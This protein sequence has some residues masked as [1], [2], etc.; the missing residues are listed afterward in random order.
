MAI[1]MTAEEIKKY[2]EKWSKPADTAIPVAN[3]VYPSYSPVKKGVAR[4]I[5]LS[6]SEIEKYKN[7]SPEDKFKRAQKKVNALW[8]DIKPV[9]EESLG[10]KVLSGIG[11]LGKEIIR[12]PASVGILGYNE[13]ASLIPA[14]QGNKKKAMEVLQ[15]ERFG[16]KP[17]FTG[18]EKPVEALKKF[19][20]YGIDAATLLYAPAK[21]VAILGK[22]LLKGKALNTFFN[23]VLTGEKYGIA[24]GVSSGLKENKGA[25]EIFES[26]ASG[27]AAGTLF[28]GAFGTVAGAH[29][30]FTQKSIIDKGSK[31]VNNLLNLTKKNFEF[32]KNPGE[33]IVR[34]GIIFS[35]AKEGF[36]KVVAKLEPLT[37]EKNIVAQSLINNKYVVSFE[38]VIRFI[39]DEIKKLN[40]FKLINSEKISY[41]E[42]LKADFLKPDVKGVATINLKKLSF[43]EAADIQQDLVKT[44]TD[45][46]QDSP[47][48]GK[49]ILQQLYGLMGNVLKKADRTG[50][51]GPLNSRISDLLSAKKAFINTD[52]T[53]KAKG[54][55]N[56]LTP[57]NLGFGVSPI[58]YGAMSG[59]PYYLAF[60]IGSLIAKGIFQKGKENPKIVSSILYALNKLSLPVRKK[61]LQAVPELLEQPAFKKF[62]VEVP[63]PPLTVEQYNLRYRDKFRRDMEVATAMKNVFGKKP[64][65]LGQ[66]EPLKPGELPRSPYPISLR[67]RGE[68]LLNEKISPKELDILASE[69]LREWSMGEAKQVAEKAKYLA[70]QSKL[71]EPFDMSLKQGN[72]SKRLETG[73]GEYQVFPERPSNQVAKQGL[74][75]KNPFKKET[76]T[77][78]IKTL[79][80]PTNPAEEIIAKSEGDIL[81][82]LQESTAGKRLFIEQEVGSPKVIRQPST[83]PKWIPDDLRL[84]TVVQPV[85]AHI[86][87]GTIPKKV[88]EVRL[89]N[90]ISEMFDELRVA[91]QEVKTWTDANPFDE[92]DLPKVINKIENEII[93]PNQKLY[94]QARINESRGE[95]KTVQGVSSQTQKTS[96]KY[97]S[98]EPITPKK[99]FKFID[100]E[101][102]KYGKK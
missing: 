52:L 55:V 93:K 79:D 63:N 83:F 32:N 8:S 31:L 43:K 95:V 61:V 88:S 100:S 91:K 17:A 87:N 6:K 30:L 11:N 34:E 90:L 47:V 60:G 65:Q 42:K 44:L 59:N 97:K 58:V 54:H 14:M 35:T 57:Y 67:G 1:S 99:A 29:T 40:P 89:Y 71:R 101:K 50:K 3:P 33:A 26:G 22:G 25:G 73:K 12:T 64:L 48:Y 21:E 74:L 69:R 77:K 28:G 78:Q 23:T 98:G 13:A 75:L 36:D 2:R 53:Q 45:W 38:N 92:M 62:K 85:V 51:F 27:G 39:D 80:N 82:G 4:G 72:V 86:I 49:Q 10:S 16:I 68:T 37:K 81:L 19:A 70:E 7:P 24:T 41:L 84:N 102:R 15:K 96:P 5:V 76:V 18:K 20:G 9:E 46:K 94:D 66:G 56:H